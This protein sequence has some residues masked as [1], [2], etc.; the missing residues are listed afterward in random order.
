MKT[1][2]WSLIVSILAFVA[3]AGAMRYARSQAKSAEGQLQVARRVHREQNEPYVIVDIQP[4]EPGSLLLV[5][6]IQNVG[7]TVARDVKIKVTPN[8]TSTAGDDVGDALTQVLSRT[9]TMMPPGRR[10][11]Y[12]FDSATSRFGS[13][14]PMVF[15]FT[16]NSEGPMGPVE[17][18]KYTVD[19][20]VLGDALI[21]RRVTKPIEE[22]LDKIS[23]S[24]KGLNDS[25]QE[26]NQQAITETRHRRMEEVRRRR[27][28]R[29]QSTNGGSSGGAP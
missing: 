28:A 17:E 5:L 22:R 23:K 26:A 12:P 2:H 18:L 8:L 24:L 1:E 7:L 15:E 29:R 19:L 4:Q 10:L 6:A 20:D 14:L 21:G 3:A 16:V 11:E 9:I 27:E 25:Y 13:G